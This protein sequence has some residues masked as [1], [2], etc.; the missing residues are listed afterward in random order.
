MLLLLIC[1]EPHTQW[2]K[3]RIRKQI[4]VSKLQPLSNYFKLFGALSFEGCFDMQGAFAE[5]AN[6][7]AAT[8]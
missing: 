5:E 1:G 4:K 6:W 8:N 3:L 2:A 7:L